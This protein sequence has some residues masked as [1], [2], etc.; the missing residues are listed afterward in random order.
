MPGVESVG[1]FHPDGS[2]YWPPSTQVGPEDKS[3]HC[4]VFWEVTDLEMLAP[5]QRV[6]IRSLHD[7]RGRKY[8]A[9]FVPEGPIL[10]SSTGYSD[11]RESVRPGKMWTHNG[12]A[13]G[14]CTATAR[15]ARDGGGTDLRTSQLLVR[16]G[17]HRASSQVSYAATGQGR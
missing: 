9:D 6:P 15:L 5:D 8:A 17:D 12:D 13:G 2:R 11:R 3:R 16:R 7:R 10:L 14:T 1:G 4:A